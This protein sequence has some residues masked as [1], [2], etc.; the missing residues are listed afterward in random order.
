MAFRHRNYAAFLKK[1]KRIL[2]S[3][4]QR[5][6]GA[7]FP[8][9]QG[10]YEARKID[11]YRNF[12]SQQL[13][14]MSSKTIQEQASCIGGTQTTFVRHVRTKNHRIYKH[15]SQ[16][17]PKKLCGILSQVRVPLVNRELRC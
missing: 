10:K 17:H 7:S 5:A 6:P 11:C 4:V 8:I 13:G 9:K 2:F 12:S 15:L 14:L 1:R 3:V 16:H